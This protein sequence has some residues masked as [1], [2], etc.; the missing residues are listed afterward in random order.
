MNRYIVGDVLAALATL[1]DESVDVTVTSPPYYT[2]RR[3]GDDP[4]EGGQEAH[5][6]DYRAWCRQWGAQLLRVTKPTGTLWLNI[7]DSSAGSGGPG[8]DYNAGGSKEDRL[9]TRRGKSDVAGGQ[10]NSLPSKVCQDFQSLGWY[11]RSQVVW[12]KGKPRREARAHVK[13]PLLTWEPVFMLTKAR[14]GYT[15]NPDAPGAFADVWPIAPGLGR[16]VRTAHPAVFPPELVRQALE[17]SAVGPG[18]VVA[19]PFC[20]RGTT[21]STAAAMGADGIGCDLYNFCEVDAAIIT[22][23]ASQAT[24]L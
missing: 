21:L 23:D 3:Y 13:R 5:A 14:T 9:R 12:W 19:D 20:G 8:G 4:R 15:W 10:W 6:N 18:M 2:L 1:P 22:L 17:C 24:G 16:G 7:G 11:C